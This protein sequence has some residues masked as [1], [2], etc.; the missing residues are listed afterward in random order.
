MGAAEDR[1]DG[2]VSGEGRKVG[3]LMGHGMTE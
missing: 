1:G 2:G 3:G